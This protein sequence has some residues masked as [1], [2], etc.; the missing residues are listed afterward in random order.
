MFDLYLFTLDEALEITNQ[1][2]TAETNKTAA[3]CGK[4]VRIFS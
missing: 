2:A 1:F 4:T 3:F